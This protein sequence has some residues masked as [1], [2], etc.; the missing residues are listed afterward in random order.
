MKIMKAI[1]I[2]TIVGILVVVLNI[3]NPNIAWASPDKIVTIGDY[4]H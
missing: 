2:V 1:K 4:E 3:L